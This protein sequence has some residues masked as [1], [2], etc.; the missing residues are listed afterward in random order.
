MA[1]ATSAATIFLIRHADVTPPTTT[2]QAL[3]AAGVVRAKELRHVL[4]D[5]GLKAVMTTSLKRSRQTGAPIAAHLG[6]VPTVI[7]DVSAIVA[8]ILALPRT[9]TALVVGHSNTLGAIISGLGGPAIAPITATEFD[10]LFVLVGRRLA[11]LRYGA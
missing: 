10:N 5:A 1:T 3:N 2:T 4:D 6:I 9:Q 7:D 11:H 8:A